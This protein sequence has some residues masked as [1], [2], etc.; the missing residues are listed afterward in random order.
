MKLETAKI[1]RSWEEEKRIEDQKMAAAAAAAA[2][3]VGADG[4]GELR[5]RNGESKFD[6]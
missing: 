1:K 2:D 4:I 6:L 3:D 5:Q